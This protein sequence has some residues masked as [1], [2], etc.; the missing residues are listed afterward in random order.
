MR[1][2]FRYATRQD[3]DAISRAL[4]PVYQA[5]TVAEA[6]E[7]FGASG[8]I[9]WSSM[10]RA[11]RSPAYFYNEKVMA[12]LGQ[13][14]ARTGRLNPE[15]IKRGF[16]ALARFAA[17][18][19]SMDIAPLT[20]VATA[21]VREAEDGPAFQRRVEKETG[22]KLHVIDGEEEARLSAQS[23]RLA[24]LAP[25]PFADRLVE[26]FQLPVVGWR[27]RGPRTR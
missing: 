9:G 23:V 14:M 3:W 7:R 27:G 13:D 5:A 12:G 19:R 10:P 2:S 22:L 24:R 15:G 21:A 26:K 20:C 25:T 6:E 18:A 4:K 17:L 11:A 8:R 16:S 1:A